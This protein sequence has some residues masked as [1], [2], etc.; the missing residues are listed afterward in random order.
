MHKSTPWKTLRIRFEKRRTINEK[1][2]KHREEN[3]ENQ[4]EDGIFW[5]NKEENK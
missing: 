2:K 3:D 1:K 4:N 5:E